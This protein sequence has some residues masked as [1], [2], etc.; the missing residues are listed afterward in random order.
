MDVNSPFKNCETATT[1]LLFKSDRIKMGEFLNTNVLNLIA[2][3][4]F[5]MI[6]FIL[7]K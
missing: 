1:I 2:F 3:L 6:N 4:N 7:T 5:I